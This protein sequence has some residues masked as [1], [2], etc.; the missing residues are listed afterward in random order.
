MILSHEKLDLLLLFDQLQ[1]VDKKQGQKIFCNFNFECKK[2]PS[3]T[4]CTEMHL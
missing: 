4:C 1:V 3:Y 2:N